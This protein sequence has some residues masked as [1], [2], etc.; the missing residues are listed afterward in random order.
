MKIRVGVKGNR[1]TLNGKP[2]V[3][4]MR[5][6]FAV[7]TYIDRWARGQG[8][9]W[10]RKVDDFFERTAAIGCDGVRVFGE[11]RGWEGRH[12]FFGELATSE[13]W[14]YQALRRGH[15]PRQ[16]T[17]HNQKCIRKL[18]ELLRKHGLIAEYVTDATLKHDDVSA[19][20]SRQTARFFREEEERDGDINIFHELHNEWDAHNQAGLDLNELR[21]Q[22][23]RHR[24]LDEVGEPEQWPRGIVG[25]SHGGR[26]H[27]AYPVGRPAGA[28][29]VAL[30]PDRGGEWWKHTNL[31]KRYEHFPR[32]YNESKCLTSNKEWV[33]WVQP[34]HFRQSACTKDVDTYLEYMRET[35]ANG[36]SF[37]IHDVVGMEAG[38][39]DGERALVTPLEK[40]LAPAPTPPPPPPP[41]EPP[42]E[43]PWWVRLWEWLVW[44]WQ[45]PARLR[46]S[47]V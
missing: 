36:I 27:I 20:C 17:T 40:E 46:G 16:L 37:C 7:M 38:W 21:M 47:R 24:R 26:D 12:A 18:I 10:L 28:D 44:S 8:G 35:I 4:L 15:R 25:V 29:Y 13:M 42:E 43:K 11:T 1:F 22:F 45:R 5:S 14:D 9:H 6:G 34:G 3:L 32:Y 41:P 31:E 23:A 2:K 30:H 39:W 19:A 33:K